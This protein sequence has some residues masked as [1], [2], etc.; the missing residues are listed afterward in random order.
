MKK[1]FIFILCLVIIPSAFSL[2]NETIYKGE[3][4]SDEPFVV[5]NKT[6][7]VVYIRETNVT[8]VYY[9]DDIQ[10]VIYSNE[11]CSVEWIYKVCRTG[12]VKYYR[13]AREVPYYAH[14]GN[15]NISVQIEIYS[16][17]A[18]LFL[19]KQTDKTE[20][21]L[22]EKAN[23]NLNIKN[24]GEL[25]AEN[26]IMKDS[27][28]GFSIVSAEGCEIKGQYVS[29]LGD[30]KENR[31]KSCDIILKAIEQGTHTN[32]LYVNYTYL[33]RS[34]LKTATNTYKVKGPCSFTPTALNISIKPNQITMLNLSVEAFTECK[35]N[36]TLNLPEEFMI[37]DYSTE[38]KNKKNSFEFTGTEE[39]KKGLN[40]TLITN[41]TGDFVVNYSTQC[42]LKTWNEKQLTNLYLRS[43]LEVFDILILSEANP[44]T[45]RVTNPTLYT[46]YNISLSTP[47][48]SYHIEELKPKHY[49]EFTLPELSPIE[50]TYLTQ[51]GQQLN[52]M[53]NPPTITESKKL[54]ATTAQTDT[55]KKR[56]F[57]LPEIELKTILIVGGVLLLI[58]LIVAY[59]MT[60]SPSS[61]LDKEIDELKQQEKE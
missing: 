10:D 59:I 26:I 41:Y 57:K 25:T 30:L 48:S 7:E 9:P 52:F 43:S 22:G 31:A 39:T 45:I 1:I 35:Y 27:Y 61:D 53:Y 55:D 13:G 14:E 51:Y 29:W 11:T 15:L 54:D 33:D 28:P 23:V 4:W 49:K 2:Y 37:L 5:N 18:E 16:S 8:V 12:D 34:S 3:V 42:S 50:I 40:I 38:F 60:R 56:L 58:F 32:N 24:I 21:F 46:F 20:L 44:A 19:E 47:D 36:L 17:N 6:Y